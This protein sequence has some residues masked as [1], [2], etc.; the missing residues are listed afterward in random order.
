MHTVP[1]LGGV[2]DCVGVCD[3]VSAIVRKME[4]GIRARMSTGYGPMRKDENMLETGGLCRDR[5]HD[6]VINKHATG[7]ETGG[8]EI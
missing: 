3:K 7:L 4:I 6:P 1:A 5:T 8:R 2:A